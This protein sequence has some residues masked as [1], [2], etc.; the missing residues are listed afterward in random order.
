MPDV[1][2]V[3]PNFYASGASY[4]GPYPFNFAAVPYAGNTTLVGGSSFSTLANVA[5]VILPL[6]NSMDNAPANG[7]F[8]SGNA[9][10]FS[11]TGIYGASYNAAAGLYKNLGYTPWGYDGID[12]TGEGL[13]DEWNE[14]L[15]EFNPVTNTTVFN[16]PVPSPDDPRHFISLSQLI[17]SRLA[18]HKHNTARAEALYALLVEGSGPLGSAFSRDDFSDKEVQDTDGDGLPE[19]VDAWGKPLQFFRWPVLYHSDFQR[20]Q[21]L[22]S[23]SAQ[24]W[25]LSYPYGGPFDQREQDTLDPNQQLMAPSWWAKAGAGGLAA[26][27]S[28]SSSAFVQATPPVPNVASGGVATFGAFFHRLFEPLGLPVQQPPPTQQGPFQQYTWSRG[29]GYRRAFFSKFL[30]LSGGLDGVPGVFLYPDSALQGN[31]PPLTAAL[32]LIANE[33]VAMQFGLDFVDF[34]QSAVIQ[35]SAISG[36]SSNDPNIP[37]SVDIQNAGQDDITNHNVQSAGGLGGPGS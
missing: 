37:N 26:N 21:V 16:P 28:Y 32:S 27:D 35:N 15:T 7:S 33:N 31:T 3:D 5:P 24:S 14:G 30:I 29:G 2:F 13:I 36:I 6:G 17:A 22:S 34:T 4:A 12:N 19:F 23:V 9:L 20:G 8:G 11:G 18:N 10:N 25:G 1:F